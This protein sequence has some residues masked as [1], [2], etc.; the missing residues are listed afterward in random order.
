MKIAHIADTHLRQRQYGVP[1]RGDDFV[2][3]LSN[4]IKRHAKAAHPQL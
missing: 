1:G 2:T 4:A 3:G